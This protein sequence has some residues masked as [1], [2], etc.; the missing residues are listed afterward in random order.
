MP[1]IETSAPKK[2]SQKSWHQI[3]PLFG[4]HLLCILKRKDDLKNKFFESKFI[5]LSVFDSEESEKHFYS[6]EVDM[7]LAWVTKCMNLEKKKRKSI[8]I[9]NKVKQFEQREK[10]LSLHQN[11]I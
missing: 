11:R 10:Y 1:S 4:K 2:F 5:N 8:T 9:V 3:M 7:M 6:I